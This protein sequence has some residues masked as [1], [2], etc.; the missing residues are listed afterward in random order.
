MLGK[1]RRNAVLDERNKFEKYVYCTEKRAVFFSKRESCG[2]PISKAIKQTYLRTE[3]FRLSYVERK[4]VRYT[5]KR[6]H[7]NWT[8][9]NHEGTENVC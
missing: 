3:K 6:H 2:G 7:T 8:M 4:T 1:L 9:G 5:Q